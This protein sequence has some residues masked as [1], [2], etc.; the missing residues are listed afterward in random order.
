MKKISRRDLIAASGALALLP[1]G[2]SMA[3]AAPD[4]ASAQQIIEPN[5]LDLERAQHIR[6]LVQQLN[7]TFVLSSSPAAGRAA[8]TETTASNWSEAK[9]LLLS[10]KAQKNLDQKTLWEKRTSKYFT[11]HGRPTVEETKV[12]LGE[13]SALELKDSKL[14]F[15]PLMTERR[16]DQA[17]VWSEED[18]FILKIAK[19]DGAI[20]NIYRPAAEPN[21]DFNH[22]ADSLKVSRQ[23]FA[24]LAKKK[25]SPTLSMTSYTAEDMKEKD[26]QLLSKTKAHKEMVPLDYALGEEGR[27]LAAEY[28]RR[29]WTNY[30]PQY[31]DYEENGGDCTNFVSQSMRYGGWPDQPGNW[32]STNSWWCN[33]STE[34]HSW[35]SVEKFYWFA[36][37]HNRVTRTDRATDLG[38]GNIVQVRHSD[39]YG[40]THSAVVTGRFFGY[41]TLTYHTRDTLDIP[42]YRFRA[43]YNEF[44]P[45][46]EFAFFLN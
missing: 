32:G 36:Q 2:A 37:T 19:N 35:I 24:S 29:H 6:Q 43:R 15:V 18:P 23:T 21:Q 45:G 3:A 22:L 41:P 42:F 39:T 14:L 28:A 20:E 13:I 12:S 27:Y 1:A 38:Y 33:E 31:R 26:Q 8:A 34:S 46:F 4:Q 44:E 17:H 16:L 9:K 10:E 25:A 7:K 11:Q 40:W 5:G 30:N